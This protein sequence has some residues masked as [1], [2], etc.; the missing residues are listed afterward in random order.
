MYR[1]SVES[2]SG[3]YE[4]FCFRGVMADERER[5]F[6]M[7]LKQPVTAVEWSALIR[8]IRAEVDSTTVGSSF[9]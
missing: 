8:N 5:V 4:G 9:P 7:K 3:G 6:R 1:R 2:E